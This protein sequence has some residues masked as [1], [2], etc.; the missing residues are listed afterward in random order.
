MSNEKLDIQIDKFMVRFNIMCRKER[1]H[2]LI[3]QRTVEYEYS[4]EIKKF[5]VTYRVKKKRD[6]WLIEAVSDGFWIFRRRYPLLRITRNDNRIRFAG[7]FTS[8]I[9]DFDINLLEEKLDEYLVICKNQPKNVFTE[10]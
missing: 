3:R 1:R 5:E 9:P 10:S 2:F 6:E 8:T 7:M 4:S